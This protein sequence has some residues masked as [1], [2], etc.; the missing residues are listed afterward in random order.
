MAA[1]SFL[2]PLA[3]MGLLALPALWW[4][5]RATPPQPAP[6]PFPP[7]R[8]LER[9]Q[10]TENTP[11]KTPW[12]LIA[13][14]A[15][16]LTCLI[17]AFAGPIWR[18]ADPITLPGDNDGPV[19]IV[20]QSD[21]ASAPGW[22]AT[23]A[24]AQRLIEAA[25]AQD[26]PVGVLAFPQPS[27][28]TPL[29]G[30][31]AEALASLNGLEPQPV[32]MLPGEMITR[33]DGL[34][35]N[36]AWA[37]AS[38]VWMGTGIQPDEALLAW[39][40]QLASEHPLAVVASQ[41]PA[42]TLRLD[43]GADGPAVLLDRVEGASPTS[44]F[45]LAASDAAGRQLATASL[46]DEDGILRERIA[47]D[48]P[49]DLRNDIARIA[50]AP[51]A[52]VGEV[53]L[54][55]DR[56]E[57]RRVGVVGAERRGEAQPL[58]SGTTFVERALTPI[59]DV[60]VPRSGDTSGE[61]ASMIEEGVNVIVLV[62]VASLIPSTV[63]LLEAWI[64]DGGVL[65]RFAS[66]GLIQSADALLPVPLRAVDRQLGGA[67][68][69]EAPQTIAPFSAQSPFA[70]LA[71]PDDVRIE[72]QVLS[73]PG[74]GLL[75]ST[76]A[77]LADATPLV[78]GVPRGD[79]YL[80]LFH[81]TADTS[82]SNLPLSGLFLDMMGRLVALSTPTGA[83]S[84]PSADAAAIALAPRATLNGFGALRSPPTHA[85]GLVVS[86]QAPSPTLANPPGFYGPADG[87]LALNLFTDAPGFIAQTPE[88]LAKHGLQTLTL[89]VEEAISLRPT[90]LGLAAFLA[91]VDGVVALAL[92]GALAGVLSGTLAGT[93]F[94]RTAGTA[95]MI[96]VVGVVIM[97]GP[98]QH[99]LAQNT[100]EANTELSRLIAAANS[101]RL[102]YVITGN[103]ELD[104]RS[105]EGLTGLSSV[106]TQRTAFEPGA[107]M[108][109]DPSRDELAFYPLIYWPMPEEPIAVSDQLIARIDAYM[110]NGGTILF[111]TRDEASNFASTSISPQ[112]AN[113]RALLAALDIPALEPVPDDHVLTKSFYLI[114][115]FPGRFATGPLWVEALPDNAQDLD[116]PA[117]GGDGV[118]PLMITGNDYASAW[119]LSPDGRPLYATSP[120]D[121][122]QR[123][124]AFRTGINIGMY[125]MTGNYKADQVHI[126]ALLER[127]VQ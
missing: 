53:I 28:A 60:T 42:F 50:I 38:L 88:T 114:D 6:A 98:T 69:W 55:D 122:R 31:R 121:P 67:L 33:V 8:L 111:D 101:T 63:S 68:T 10:K 104:Q 16:L 70:G 23:L 72:R 32:T 92:S 27:F 25:D 15:M 29:P 35:Q 93:V 107:P 97:G 83:A 2:A 76:Y 108:A 103:S 22:Q 14:R 102:A 115:S 44:L 75:A 123:E 21:W 52:H 73:E 112:T 74:A 110:N 48:L 89:A 20:I 105:R 19:L 5:L 119:A 90:L 65:V 71:V 18:A 126:P 47:F 85:E 51:A 77:E 99:T 56:L 9:L 117:R 86:A 34:L 46:L 84:Q 4:L 80:V 17:L 1:L 41:A 49:R 59:A 95:S 120:P 7:L 57:R 82:W 124:F 43:G 12:W 39:K 118:T 125:V 45:T 3:L 109:V 30:D 54:V 11:N 100:S 79:G 37:N 64:E 81:V 66:S 96:F 26:R 40:T 127:L 94:R 36:I 91:L 113:L 58:L 87:T 61:I 13:L 24:G 62:D 106:L 116:R 78:S